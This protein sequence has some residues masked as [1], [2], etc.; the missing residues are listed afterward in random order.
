MRYIILILSSLI[1]FLTKSAVA[2]CFNCNFGNKNLANSV[3]KDQNLSYASFDGA[4]LIHAQLSKKQILE[5]KFCKNIVADAMKFSGV[6]K[7]SQN[8]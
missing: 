7:N 8:D 5:S 2:D 3:F 6:C 4:Y 1:F